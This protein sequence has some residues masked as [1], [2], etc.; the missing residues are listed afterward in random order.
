V[1]QEAENREVELT[2]RAKID[3]DLN[4]NAIKHRDNH[5]IDMQRK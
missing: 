5:N 3:P 2:D 4:R 1:K